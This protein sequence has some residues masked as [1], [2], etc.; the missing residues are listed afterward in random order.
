LALAPRASSGVKEMKTEPEF[1]VVPL[2]LPEP[3]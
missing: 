1:V 3:V 2:A